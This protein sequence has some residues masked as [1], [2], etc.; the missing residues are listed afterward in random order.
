MLNRIDR[1]HQLRTRVVGSWNE[2]SKFPSSVTAVRREPIDPSPLSL[3]LDNADSTSIMPVATAVAQSNTRAHLPSANPLRHS[4]FVVAS[5]AHHAL[6]NA[7]SPS[8]HKK[9]ARIAN[10]RGCR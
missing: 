3:A 5:S 8:R 10:A 9:Q 1:C 4:N 6:E 2:Q 7:G